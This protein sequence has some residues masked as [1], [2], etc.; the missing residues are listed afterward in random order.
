MEDHFAL[1]VV[2]ASGLILVDVY[3]IYF[4]LLDIVL[5]PHLMDP[6]V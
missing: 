3:Y 2:L 4:M 1:R 5:F 6:A